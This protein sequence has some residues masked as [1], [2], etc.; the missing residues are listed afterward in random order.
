MAYKDED[1]YMRD[2]EQEGGHE[3]EIPICS[4]EFVANTWQQNKAKVQQ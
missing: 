4:G 3:Y 2:A 1:M